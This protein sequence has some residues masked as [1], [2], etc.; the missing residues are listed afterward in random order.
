MR[1][2]DHQDEK[3]ISTDAN[4]QNVDPHF[5]IVDVNSVITQSINKS[6]AKSAHRRLNIENN[7]QNILNRILLSLIDLREQMFYYL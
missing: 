2:D 5:H 4:H 3:N 6:S 1:I 7:L